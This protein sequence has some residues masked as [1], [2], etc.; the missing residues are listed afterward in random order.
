MSDSKKSKEEER[1]VVLQQK[2]QGVTTFRKVEI[3][4]GNG[5]PCYHGWI[6]VFD[7]GDGRNGPTVFHQNYVN[8][9]LDRERVFKLERL[10]ET[11]QWDKDN[12]SIREAVPADLDE[13]ID[14]RFQ[15]FFDDVYDR[16][17]AYQG[18][19]HKIDSDHLT[20]LFTVDGAI[21]GL[22]YFDLVMNAWRGEAYFDSWFCAPGMRSRGVG[23]ALVKAGLDK[24][25]ELGFKR[26]SAGVLGSEEHCL[27]NAGIL[28]SCC[29][30]TADT[31]YENV[32]GILQ[33]ELSMEL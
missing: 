19:M 16:I 25:R 12:I 24:V 21:K 1:V 2:G 27:H 6:Q 30:F 8:H 17:S 31:C 26:V 20:L 18:L 10:W 14:L 15:G 11:P 23:T 28:R 3:A 32:P 4:Y 33:V 7:D 9:G 5:S 29:G 13:I 22:V